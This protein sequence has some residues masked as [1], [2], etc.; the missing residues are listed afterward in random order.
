[1]RRART[2]GRGHGNQPAIARIGKVCDGL[3]GREP[4][5]RKAWLVPHHAI[6]RDR[7]AAKRPVRRIHRKAANPRCSRAQ[8]GWNRQQLAGLAQNLESI[9]CRSPEY[10]CLEPPAG[11]HRNGC[12]CLPVQH[13][14]AKI[15]FLRLESTSERF[16]ERSREGCDHHHLLAG[17]PGL[18]SASSRPT[19][20]RVRK[21]S[22]V[23]YAIE[24]DLPGLHKPLWT[25]HADAHMLCPLQKRSE[26]A[27]QA[28]SNALK[29]RGGDRRLR[30]RAIETKLNGGEPTCRIATRGC[31]FRSR[32]SA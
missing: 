12:G 2:G 7:E 18:V 17:E 4:G 25:I 13:P 21:R 1:M 23:M 29:S 22:A 5:A 6:A 28:K 24:A 11:D 30:A 26:A 16:I 19:S 31:A 9:G 8:A 10:I 27:N 32:K 15:W 3:R 14:Q 20:S